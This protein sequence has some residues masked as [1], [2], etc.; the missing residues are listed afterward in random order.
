MFEKKWSSGE[1]KCDVKGCEDILTVDGGMKPNRFICA[2]KL[3]GVTTFSSSGIKVLSGCPNKPAP[4]SKYCSECKDIES[5]VQVSGSVSRETKD[6]L[7]KHRSKTA[8]FKESNQDQIYVIES[9]LDQKQEGNKVY[10]KVKWLG[11]PENE[12]TWE[13]EKN[14]QKW[15]TDFY[16]EDLGRL[17]KTLPKPNI[18]C[19]K[20]SSGQTYYYLGW[21][22]NKEE[23]GDLPLDKWVTDDFFQNCC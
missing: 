17:G 5:P 21:G 20:K 22:N 9:L 18:K 4:T 7:R 23:A 16:T 14:I 11:F 10:W 2:D 15:M 3:A 13:P 6:S 1:H 12:S 19:Q 8:Q